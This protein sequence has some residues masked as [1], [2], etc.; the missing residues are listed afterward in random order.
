VSRYFFDHNATSAPAAEVLAGMV[1]VYA[2][3]IGNPSSIHTDGQ[4]ARRLIEQARAKAAAMLGAGAKEIVFTSGG[5]EAANLAVLGAVRA[6]GRASK[7]VVTT[8]IEH[9]AVMGACGQLERE[10][11]AVTY[12]APNR[13]GIVEPERVIRQ[14]HGGTALVSVMHA[15]NETGALQPVEEIARA[16]RE[17]GVLFHSDGVQAAGKLGVNVKELSADLYSISGHKFGALP[18]VGA[19]YVRDGVKLEPLQFGGRHERE[20]RAGTEN[21]LAIW[22]LGVAC[23]LPRFDASPLRDRLEQ[24]I[25]SRIGGVTLNTGASPRVGNTSNLRF[26]GIGGESVVIALD[27]KGFAVSTGSACS[28]GS[29]EPSHVLLAMGLAPPEARSSVRFSLGRGNDEAQ[30]E[31]LVEAVVDSV[32]HL[33]RVSPEVS[34]A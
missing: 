9:Q 32:A 29:V 17:K 14:I 3:G 31:A 5:T 6:D 8:S 20:R 33:R 23:G 2:D 30:V 13:D 11:V 21:T 18:G 12:V 24:G 7:H 27:L 19:L 25:L 22:S 1:E 10:G 15:N 26:A 16:C 34:H 28:S 4:R